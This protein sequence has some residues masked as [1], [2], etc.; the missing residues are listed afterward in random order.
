VQSNRISQGPEKPLA[1]SILAK[2]GQIAGVAHVAEGNYDTAKQ[3]GYI[4][5]FSLR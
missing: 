1:K 5:Y 4:E 3:T 2:L